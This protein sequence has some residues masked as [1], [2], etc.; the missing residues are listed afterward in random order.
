MARTR[1]IDEIA[2]TNPVFT[3]DASVAPRFWVKVDK[4][5][6][7]GCWLWTA[8]TTHGYGMFRSG[9]R[10]GR[11]VHAHRVAWALTHG[12][13]PA[14]LDVL[15]RCDNPPCVRPSHLFL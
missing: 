10:K 15:H 1:L 4:S 2:Y 7:L 8:A 11:T 9:G 14:G 3:V 13:V 5:D 12:F 6:G